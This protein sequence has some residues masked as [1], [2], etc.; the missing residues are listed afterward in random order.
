MKHIKTESKQEQN[1]RQKWQFFVNEQLL[2][3]KKFTGCRLK[4]QW[5][6]SNL[7]E[8]GFIAMLPTDLYN[9]ADIP[10]N[11]IAGSIIMTC[12]VWIKILTDEKEVIFI[13]QTKAC[14][15]N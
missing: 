15:I 6:Q 9:G 8:E 11:A 13:R 1:Q 5:T 14:P 10:F 7:F 12:N 3:L 2:S 4:M